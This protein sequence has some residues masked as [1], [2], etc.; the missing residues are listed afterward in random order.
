MGNKLR[1]TFVPSPEKEKNFFNHAQDIIIGQSPKRG[2]GTCKNV[3][4]VSHYP[5]FV[6]AEECICT[7]GLQCDTVLFE[8]NHCPKWVFCLD[9]VTP[10]A[11]RVE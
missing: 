11:E 7:V 3:K 5:G 8:V 6:T 10:L 4:C 2:C 9:G 1:E